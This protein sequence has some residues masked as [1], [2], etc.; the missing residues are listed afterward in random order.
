[1]GRRLQ[2]AVVGSKPRDRQARLLERATG[3][4]GVRQ[5]GLPPGDGEHRSQ[6]SRPLPVGGDV[7]ARALLASVAGLPWLRRP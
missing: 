4:T 5:S 2:S 3:W 7:L 1:M 6:H